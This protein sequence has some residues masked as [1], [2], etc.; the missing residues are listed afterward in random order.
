MAANG[1][2]GLLVYTATQA[3]RNR[4]A[5]DTMVGAAG[6]NGVELIPVRSDGAIDTDALS[7]KDAYSAASQSMDLPSISLCV[8]GGR[9]NPCYIELDDG[10]IF[11]KSNL[12]FAIPRGPFGM[13]HAH[14][15]DMGVPSFNPSGFAAVANSKIATLRMA[16]RLG[17][18]FKTVRAMRDIASMAGQIR[19]PIVAKPDDGHGGAGVSLLE[20]DS[21][22][23]PLIGGKCDGV[24]LLQDVAD[25][26]GQDMRVYVLD[27]EIIA[28]MLRTGDGFLSNYTKGGKADIVDIDTLDPYIAESVGKIIDEFG[29]FFGGVDFLRDGDGWVLGEI[30]DAVG[31]RM[32]YDKTDIDP[33]SMFID[34]VCRRIDGGCGGS[35]I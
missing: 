3:A 2:T 12:S 10:R 23:A 32:L 9:E 19:Y 25:S 28:A 11:D 15:D 21:D 13:L 14:L 35:S 1:E 8:D 29:S 17:I 22:A 33:F 34:S 7:G 5:I 20:C 24:T 16:S 26:H 30:E 18:K 31:C 6:R 4:F 27:G